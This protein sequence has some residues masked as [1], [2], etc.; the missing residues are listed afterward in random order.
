MAEN[1]TSGM[2]VSIQDLVDLCCS[3]EETVS[4]KRNVSLTRHFE[5]LDS[6]SQKTI[7]KAVKSAPRWKISR[8]RMATYD[9]KSQQFIFSYTSCDCEKCIEG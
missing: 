4:V 9:E 1:E 7:P 8:I 6:G 5:N 3:N 2:I